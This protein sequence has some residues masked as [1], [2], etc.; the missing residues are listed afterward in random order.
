M[1]FLLWPRVDLP[2]VGVLVCTWSA[3]GL[4]QPLGECGA[5]RGESRLLFSTTA[6]VR[7]RELSRVLGFFILVF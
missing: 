2:T 4:S 6:H 7:G 3:S 1:S 5:G